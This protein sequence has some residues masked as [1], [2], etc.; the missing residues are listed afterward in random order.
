MSRFTPPVNI[1]FPDKDQDRHRQNLDRQIKELQDAARNSGRGWRVV[2]AHTLL[3]TAQ[4]IAYTRSGNQFIAG[5]ALTAIW[6]I[7][8]SP[9][10]RIV[11]AHALVKPTAAA[12]IKL[13]MFSCNP[14]NL[15]QVGGQINSSGTN[16]QVVSLTGLNLRTT[17][18]V[19]VAYELLV[20]MASGDVAF[21][22][23]AETEPV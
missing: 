14:V 20:T 10:E 23:A 3:P 18:K 2:S 15:G 6:A 5:Q 17:N 1:R 7:E 4:T 22:L 13:R 9:L 16:Q 11:A 21:L 19:F 8:C 12:S